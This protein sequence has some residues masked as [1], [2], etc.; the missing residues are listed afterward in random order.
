MET[1]LKKAYGKKPPRPYHKPVETASPKKLLRLG[2]KKSGDSRLPR[3]EIPRSEAEAWFRD[4]EREYV[5]AEV[6]SR[7]LDREVH[8]ELLEHLHDSVEKALK[9]ALLSYG[10]N[11]PTGREGQDLI[12][13]AM[14]LK[15]KIDF[16]D[17]QMDFLEDLT[18]VHPRARYINA[19]IVP[20]KYYRSEVIQEYL[21]KTGEFSRWVKAKSGLKS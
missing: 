4:A 13:L 17:Q 15:D 2:S 6:L 16:T 19:G 5:A 3:R 20:P 14:L 8:R 18:A 9:G 7:S 1:R 11:Y 21:R 12:H 10:K